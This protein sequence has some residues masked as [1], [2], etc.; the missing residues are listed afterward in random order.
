MET[1]GILNLNKPEGMT[2]RQAVSKIH[3][4]V[5]PSKAGHAGTLDPL[6][7]GVLVVCLGQATRLIQEVQDSLKTYRGKFL[8]GKRSDT[9]DITGE[10]ETVRESVSVTADEL[11]SVLKQF[12][13][14]IKQVPPRFSAVHIDGKR[15]YDLARRKK[16]FEIQSRTVHV[17]SA[18]L[19]DFSSPEFELEITCG[20]GTYIRSIGRDIGEQL[21]C[22]ALMTELVRTQVGFFSLEEAI[23][24]DSLTKENLGSFLIPA[25]KA[26]QQYSPYLCNQ[27]EMNFLRNGRGFPS[28]VEQAFPESETIRLM[29]NETDL[30][31]LARYSSGEQLL[32]PF[33]VFTSQL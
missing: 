23:D 6:A 10:V 14:D 5:R 8:L 29:K 17:E 9:D 24:P 31:A 32:S 19:T 11:E 33:Q 22:G 2:S 25:S 28:R 16:D 12:V 18:R 15:A 4:L 7:T 3:R 13:G 30:V 21:G 20:S 27:D 26:V 1:F